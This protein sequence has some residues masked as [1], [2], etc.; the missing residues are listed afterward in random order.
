MNFPEIWTC[1]TPPPVGVGDGFSQSSMYPTNSPTSSLAG[2]PDVR[3]LVLIRQIW[4][5]SRATIAQRV[6]VPPSI[7]Q[8]IAEI[9]VA[10]LI[11]DKNS[12]IASSLTCRSFYIAST[13]HLHYT[14]VLEDGKGRRAWPKPLQKPSKLGLLPLVKRLELRW[15]FTSAWRTGTPKFLFDHYVLC[16]FSG[17]TNVRELEMEDLDV[18]A[19]MPKIQKYF[20]HL[21]PRLQSLSLSKAKGSNRQIIFFIGLFQRLEDLTVLGIAYDPR[22]RRPFEDQTLT[23]PS[24]PPLRGRLVV[25]KRPYFLEEMIKLFGGIQF[26][27]M[28][29]CSA[30]EP[31]LLLNACTETLEAVKLCSFDF[32][33]EQS[34]LEHAGLP[35]NDSTACSS[36]FNLSKN[37]SLQT[38][39]VM[40]G[41]FFPL[42]G[43]RMPMP[44]LKT[45]LSTIASPTFSEVIILHWGYYWPESGPTD[46]ITF[47]P[48]CKSNY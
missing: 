29:V 41:C 47:H 15:T 4:H 39:E 9:I 22:R 14:R 27:Y 44:F 25:R 42:T 45:V 17:P 12:L 11:Y 19:L 16:Q 32:C 2:N 37:K 48:Y 46:C 20:G 26:R 28:S 6:P 3:Y 33:S 18:P 23:P 40:A 38:L 13:P 43:S 36:H 7:P 35:A 31:Q 10:H 24:T 21:L 1:A 8:E 5:R 34:R 30:G